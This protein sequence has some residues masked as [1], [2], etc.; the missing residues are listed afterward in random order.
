MR[1]SHIQFLVLFGIGLGSSLVL[2]NPSQSPVVEQNLPL[3]AE[4]VEQASVPQQK[5]V[6]DGK[7]VVLNLRTL[8][9]LQRESQER[10]FA[11]K[12]ERILGDASKTDTKQQTK[13]SI[14][15][16]VKEAPQGGNPVKPV[17]GAGTTEKVTP[18]AQASV[19]PNGTLLSVFG[20]ADELMAEVYSGSGKVLTLQAGERYQGWKIQSIDY[21]GLTVH[22]SGKTRQWALGE[23]LR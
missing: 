22:Q 15:P 8:A 14:R 4:D 16:I 19:I 1:A 11:E 17:Q 23:R 9:N 10:A 6:I 21:A 18:V 20:P 12:L 7:E 5:I 3:Q 2:A 13:S